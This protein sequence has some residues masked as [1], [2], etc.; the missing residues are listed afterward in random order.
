MTPGTAS[1]QTAPSVGAAAAGQAQTSH[2]QG[3][4]AQP[5]AAPAAQHQA[6]AEA[7]ES[8][9]LLEST[10][11]RISDALHAALP[12]GQ[13]AVDAVLSACRAAM[14]K[15]GWTS[16][17]APRSIAVVIG[18]STLLVSAYWVVNVSCTPLGVLGSEAAHAHCRAGKT[19][20]NYG[21]TL[22]SS[23]SATA[24]RTPALAA[25]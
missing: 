2:G 7:P 9:S 4:A 23:A 14:T 25:T 12:Y 16:D 3:L 6:A 13:A 22:L 21:K 20:P 1:S 17:N 8:S 15:D 10:A 24:M 19:P 5:T 18:A 11:S